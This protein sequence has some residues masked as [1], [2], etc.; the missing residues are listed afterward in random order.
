VICYGS[1]GRGIQVPS[2]ARAR[3]LPLLRIGSGAHSA[4]SP[5]GAEVSSLEGKKSGHEPDHSPP[6]SA[7]VKNV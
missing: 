6:S 2:L 1:D 4:T 3:D 7:E 5:L